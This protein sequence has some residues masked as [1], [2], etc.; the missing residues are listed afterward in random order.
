MRPEELAGFVNNTGIE[1]VQVCTCAAC[2]MVAVAARR[3]LLPRWGV[4]LCR[5]TARVQPASGPRQFLSILSYG[6]RSAR[7]QPASTFLSPSWSRSLPPSLGQPAQRS[8]RRP[9]AP[10]R[11]DGPFSPPPPSD[12]SCFWEQRQWARA[13]R[14]PNTCR[15]V[16][17]MVML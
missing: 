12:R 8:G 5:Q 13:G 3:R 6:P 2:A 9:P 11:R 10:T 1:N 14:A 16:P 15:V 7:V 17:S 4:R